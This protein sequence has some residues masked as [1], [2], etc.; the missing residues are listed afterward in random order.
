MF[1][2]KKFNSLYLHYDLHLIFSYLEL[3]KRYFFKKNVL[4]IQ[5]D[6]VKSK[7]IG[8]IMVWAL[9][10]DDFSGSCGQGKYPLLHAIDEEL[11]AG[12]VQK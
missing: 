1:K 7:G 11:K 3:K 4:P 12:N 9:D 2:E 5:V 6:F 8:G 10:L